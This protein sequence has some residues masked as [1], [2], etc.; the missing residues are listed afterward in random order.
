[1]DTQELV[2]RLLQSKM[3][4]PYMRQHVKYFIRSC[5]L[6]QK[7]RAEKFPTHSHPFTTSTDVPMQCFNI[8][9]IGP[10]PDAGY[11]L[12]IIFAFTRWVELHRTPD[13]TAISAA[14]HKFVPTTAR[15]LLLT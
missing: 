7:L 10:L 3:K 11:I 5:P 1:M 6:C 12:V 2:L 4:W 9:F 13:A 8:D 14:P 15:I